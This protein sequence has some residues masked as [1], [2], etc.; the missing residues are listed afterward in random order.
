M[1]GLLVVLVLGLGACTPTV[2]EFNGGGP[3]APDQRTRDYAACQNTAQGLTIGG[4]GLVGR[5]AYN[6]A[7]KNCMVSKGYAMAAD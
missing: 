5:L 4:S 1:R 3:N 2:A 7:L 6:K